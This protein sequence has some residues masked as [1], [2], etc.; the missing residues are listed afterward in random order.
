MYQSKCCGCS[1]LLY[2]LSDS[3]LVFFGDGEDLLVIMGLLLNRC[4]ISML[5]FSEKDSS[6][7][8]ALSKLM[9]NGS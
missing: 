9:K 6:V 4:P 8:G 7:Q 1:G 2:M 5:G 3:P